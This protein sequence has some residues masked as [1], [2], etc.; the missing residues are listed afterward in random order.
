MTLSV[1]S[2]KMLESSANKSLS[3]STV[4][5]TLGLLRGLWDWL[6]CVFPRCVR[7]GTAGRRSLGTWCNVC[8]RNSGAACSGGVFLTSPGTTDGAESPSVSCLFQELPTSFWLIIQQFRVPLVF[9][10]PW[11]EQLAVAAIFCPVLLT[12]TKTKSSFLT[13][14]HAEAVRRLE[15]VA[16]GLALRPWVF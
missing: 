10:C 9:S 5:Q 12:V 7:R 6:E 4:S 3:F 2:L 13:W 8:L 15:S 1:S 16:N 14:S 11:K